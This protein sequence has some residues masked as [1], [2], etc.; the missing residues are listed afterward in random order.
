MFW[1]E[2][3]KI[4]VFIGSIIVIASGLFL[5]YHEFHEKSALSR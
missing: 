2:I 3:P 5:I 1:N 4:N